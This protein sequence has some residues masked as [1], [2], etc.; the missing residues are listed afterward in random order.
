MEAEFLLLVD[1]LKVR[2][3]SVQTDGRG[4]TSAT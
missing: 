2:W 4:R 3:L 1:M